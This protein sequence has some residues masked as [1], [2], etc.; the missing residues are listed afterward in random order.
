MVADMA[1]KERALEKALG[2]NPFGSAPAGIK[3]KPSSE[4]LAFLDS[5]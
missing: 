1:M 2:Q 5:L 3:Y 4:L